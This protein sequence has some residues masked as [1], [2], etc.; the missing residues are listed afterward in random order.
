M[1]DLQ[2]SLQLVLDY[3]NRFNSN[4]SSIKSYLHMYLCTEGEMHKRSLPIILFLFTKWL[5]GLNC[6]ID[7]V[8]LRPFGMFWI[9]KIDLKSYSVSC[10]FSDSLW[11]Q[12]STTLYSDYQWFRDFV[13]ANDKKNISHDCLQSTNSVKR[14]R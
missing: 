6:V 11:F 3:F 14:N 9:L 12:D 10:T 8:C 2:E 1:G 7:K 5:G 13:S 4:F